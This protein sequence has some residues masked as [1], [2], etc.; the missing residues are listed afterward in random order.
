MESRHFITNIEKLKENLRNLKFE[1]E[2]EFKVTDY[3]F[4]PK[5][6]KYD[7]SKQQMKIRVREDKTLLIYRE[8]KWIDKAKMDYIRISNEFEFE[9]AVRI[10]KNW[11]FEK[12]FE[13]GRMGI[14]YR[15]NEIIV[16]LEKIDYIGDMIEIEAPSIEII[17]KT[18]NE[19]D[20]ISD[21]IGKSVPSLVFEKTGSLE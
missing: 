16:S 21:K 12:I 17:D 5:G 1:R 2:K 6:K 11:N 7:L 3:L 19:L 18:I 14:R 8:Y 4:M 13:F 10:L 20:F 15:R 9:E